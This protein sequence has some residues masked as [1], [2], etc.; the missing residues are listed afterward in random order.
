[1]PYHLYNYH[2]LPGCHFLAL[3]SRVHVSF[4]FCSVQPTYVQAYL[5][6]VGVAEEHAKF[7]R[8]RL[9][10]S[11]S[12]QRCFQ[13]MAQQESLLPKVSITKVTSGTGLSGLEVYRRPTKRKGLLPG[14][15]SASGRKTSH[16]GST[17]RS[18]SSKRRLGSRRVESPHAVAKRRLRPTTASE[19]LRKDEL[20]LSEWSPLY[21]QSQTR[22][23]PDI[24]TTEAKLQQRSSQKSSASSSSSAHSSFQDIGLRTHFAETNHNADDDSEYVYG[25]YRDHRPGVHD[26]SGQYFALS[27]RRFWTLRNVIRA[28]SNLILEQRDEQAKLDYEKAQQQAVQQALLRAEAENQRRLKEAHRQRQQAELQIRLRRQ[29]ATQASRDKAAR[30]AAAKSAKLA[31]DRAAK[32]ERDTHSERLAAQRRRA[33]AEAEAEAAA[34]AVAATE[35]RRHKVR[36]CGVVW[37]WWCGVWS[38]Y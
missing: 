26:G 16:S 20:H 37:W 21:S 15:A 36:C 18:S 3:T 32:T 24:T 8:E 12:L 19:E 29:R 14:S 22:S 31:A 25:Q 33:L 17:G 1:M 30:Q 7:T 27:K 10:K 6:G 2:C 4:L 9:R 28:L 23:M 35:A 38:G 34:A 5:G 13:E 11:V